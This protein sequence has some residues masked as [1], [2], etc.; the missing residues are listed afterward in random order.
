MFDLSDA[1]KRHVESLEHTLHNL[2]AQLRTIPS[3]HQIILFGSYAA[4]R[5]D[6]FTDLDILVIMDT[7]LDFV[8]RTVTLFQQ[9]TI[10]APVDLLVYTP[11]ELQ[12]MRDRPFLR[13]ALATGKVLYEKRSES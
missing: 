9:L 8:S 2:V 3:V 5:R 1:R 7:S 11:E 10:E 12:A 13:H 6:L 4:G